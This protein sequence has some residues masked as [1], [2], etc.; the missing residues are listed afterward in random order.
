MQ[1]L[2]W[3]T[4]VAGVTL[5]VTISKLFAGL[6]AAFPRACGGAMVTMRTFVGSVLSC[7][8]CFGVYVGIFFALFGYTP[9]VLPHPA[10]MPGLGHDALVVL[11]SGAAGGLVSFTWHVVLAHLGSM[12][13]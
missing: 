6:R 11:C 3:A 4:V 5:I 7:P 12:D 8:L 10:W 13:L 2:I 9:V 1:F